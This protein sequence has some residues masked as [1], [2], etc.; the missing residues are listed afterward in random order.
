MAADHWILSADGGGT[1]TDLLLVNCSVKSG[2]MVTGAGTN[3]NAHGKVAIGRFAQLMETAL[4]RGQISGKEVGSAV[5]GLAG[6]SHPKYRADFE[7]MLER[8]LPSASV[9]MTSDAELAHRSIWGIEQGITLI[10]GTGSIAVGDDGD[11]KLLRAGGFGYQFGDIGSGYWL[12]KNLITQL[13][14]MERSQAEDVLALRE[15]VVGEFDA[16]GFE[17]AVEAASGGESI[18]G[19]AALA[20]IVLE[21]ARDGNSVAEQIA[22]SGVEGLLEI[23]EELAEKLG[24]PE[25]IGLHGSVITESSFYRSL[26]L[27]GLGFDGWKRGGTAA[28]FGGM[29][30]A[31]AVETPGELCK[32][33]INY[34]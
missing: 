10:V 9:R 15:A 31:G 4:Q 23:V 19:V 21:R 1:K 32:F 22:R 27:N 29:I 5:I 14:A 12:G 30:I 6:V 2:V 17:E 24:R 7:E 34:G 8:H 25:T 18:P 33:A 20:P 13:I 28:V 16:D 3:P 11:G 26:V